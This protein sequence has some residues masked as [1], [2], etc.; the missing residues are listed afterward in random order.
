[1]LG[2]SVARR[3]AGE[4]PFLVKVLAAAEP[5]SI[6]CH[7]DVEQARLGFARENLL[8]LPLDAKVRNYRDPHHKPELLV[9]L[10]PFMALKGFRPAS[11]IVR[12]LSPLG[13]PECLRL[14]R[15]GALSLAGQ[16]EGALHVPDVRRREDPRADRREVT[17]QAAKRRLDDEAYRWMVELH[18]RYPGDVGALGP[19]ILNLLELAPGDAVFVGAGSCTPTLGGPASRSWPTQ[20]T[21]CA[22]V[23]RPN[24]STFRS[25]SRSPASR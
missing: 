6:Q 24:T 25:C 5:L 16:P 2:R 18:D 21:S 17:A 23:S 1:M 13:V 22:V 14:G 11:D 15:P 7:P 3:F 9:A 4:L 19:G 12:L 10:K 8:G 20:T